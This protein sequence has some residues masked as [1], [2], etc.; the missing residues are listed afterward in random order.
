MFKSEAEPDRVVTA[1][2]SMIPVVFASRVFNA[3]A[4]MEVSVIVIDS[5]PNPLIPIEAYD[6]FNSEIVPNNEVIAEA[7]MI[8]AV[9]ASR[10]FNTEA[11][12]EVSEIVIDSFPNPLIPDEE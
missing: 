12:I 6:I 10:V 5:S 7:F 8:P 1:E 3:E 4:S 11:S 9:F 2:A